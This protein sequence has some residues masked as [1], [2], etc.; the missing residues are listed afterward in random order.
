MFRAMNLEFE[1]E[2]TPVRWE[3]KMN[4]DRRLALLRVIPALIPS[5]ARDSVPPPVYEKKQTVSFVGDL[6]DSIPE[7]F[8]TVLSVYDLAYDSPANRV[9]WS[10]ELQYHEGA[11]VA[12]RQRSC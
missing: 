9:S 7:L 12:D 1:A 10:G 3:L 5:A 6:A 4:G 2:N 11:A 8:R